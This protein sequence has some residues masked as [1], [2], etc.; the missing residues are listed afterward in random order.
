MLSRASVRKIERLVAQRTINAFLFDA[1]W[2]GPFVCKRRRCRHTQYWKK[3]E[4]LL[5]ECAKCHGTESIY[6]ATFMHSSHVPIEIWVKV[7]IKFLA[8]GNNVT[9]LSLKRDL[10]LSY[11]A[12]WMLTSRIRQS[13]FPNGKVAFRK[14]ELDFIEI[15]G[16]QV[17]GILGYH[18]KDRGRKKLLL[19]P[20][21][22]ISQSEIRTIFP[23]FIHDQATVTA[24]K[25]FH[26][27]PPHKGKLKNG[28]THDLDL[29]F[30]KLKVWSKS[31]HGIDDKNIE[32]YL[33]E[34][35]FRFNET[36][37][38]SVFRLLLRLK[39]RKIGVSLFHV[40]AQTPE[41]QS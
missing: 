8:L 28:K 21:R 36:S 35:S 2:N 37:A 20:I 32:T 9:S 39:P 31:F 29:V 22:S 25:L 3:R 26:F 34:F 13:M 30:K 41:Q 14:C 1:K 27:L 7:V 16:I 10:Q 5:V 6:S 12:A 18:S 33:N 11:Q 17:I 24:S 15:N 40:Y 23:L 38:A 4:G 19:L